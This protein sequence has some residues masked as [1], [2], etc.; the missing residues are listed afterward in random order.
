V[1]KKSANAKAVFII[2][3]LQMRRRMTMKGP[4]LSVIERER[5]L[6]S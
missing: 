4:F 3:R 6:S 5:N 1:N 2:K